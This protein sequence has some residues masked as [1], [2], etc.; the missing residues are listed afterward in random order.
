M[1]QLE[2]IVLDY[3]TGPAK[4]AAAEANSAIASNEKAAER[5]GQ[6]ATRASAAQG[7][8]IVRITDRSRQSTERLV[9]SVERR[10]ITLK[11]PIDRLLAEKQQ[12]LDRVGGDPAAIQRVT[13]AFDKLIANQKKVE[14]GAKALDLSGRIKSGLQ[15]PLGAAGAA[16]SSFV[17]K[18]GLIGAV[19]GGVAVGVG[20]AAKSMFDLV[21]GQG[22]AA[23]ATLNL[24]DRLGIT[25]S[26]ASVLEGQARI[27]GVSVDAFGGLVRKLSTD[28]AD[29]GSEARQTV[30][31]LEN[32]GIVV[33][34]AGG[35]FRDPI[36]ILRD[37][38]KQLN[39]L[40]DH[41]R[42]VDLLSRAFGKGAVELLPLIKNFEATERQSRATGTALDTEIKKKLAEVD[43]RLNQL[44]LSWERIKLKL[45]EKIVTGLEGVVSTFGKIKAGADNVLG[46]TGTKIASIGVEALAAAKAF[47]VLGGP[48]ALGFVAS[49]LRGITANAIEAWVAL[50]G[51]IPGIKTLLVNLADSLSRIPVILKTITTFDYAT[52]ATGIANLANATRG[53]IVAQAGGFIGAIG[54]IA[55]AIRGGG[56]LIGALTLGEKA[57]LGIGQAALIAGAGFAGWKLGEW[58]RDNVPLVREFGDALADLILRIPGVER[59]RDATW[60]AFHGIVSPAKDLA[61]GIKKATDALEAQGAVFDRQG[62]RTLPQYASY[63]ADIQSKLKGISGAADT[64][65]NRLVDAFNKSSGGGL[66]DLQR[67]LQNLVKQRESVGATIVRSNAPESSVETASVRARI[68]NARSLDKQIQA[69]KDAIKIQSG[70]ADATR[71]LEEKRRDEVAKSQDLILE[72]EKKNLEARMKIGGDALDTLAA[73]GL[74]T[75]R[76]VENEKL[77][78]Q[79]QT[80][81]QVAAL[82]KQ[83]IENRSQLEIDKLR[84][85]SKAK[86]IPA[87][88]VERTVTAINTQRDE[89]LL[90]V[91]RETADA[92]ERA[93]ADLNRGR[94]LRDR[95]FADQ[96]L[97]LRQRNDDAVAS[98]DARSAQRSRDE[99]LDSLA[100]INAQ[101]L[102]Q[103]LAVEQARTAIENRFLKISEQAN[104]Q[105]IERRLKRE[106]DLLDIQA[107]RQGISEAERMKRRSLIEQEFQIERR[108]V[109]E[110]TDAAIAANQRKTAIDSARIVNE[111]NLSIFDRFKRESEGIFDAMFA[112]GQNVFQAIGNAFKN[113]MLTAIK[114]VVSSRVAAS[115]TQLVTGQKVTLQPG[116]TGAGPLGRLAGQLGVGA[117][118]VFGK[119]PPIELKTKLDISNHLGDLQLVRGAAPV[120]VVNP[121]QGD[122]KVAAAL[123]GV[124]PAL[125]GIAVALGSLGSKAGLKAP[126][127]IVESTFNGV[128]TGP[129]AVFGV[130]PAAALGPGGTSG[131]AGPLAQSG[132]LGNVGQTTAT[133]PFVPTGGNG[134]ILG[135]LK[136]GLG[137][138]K[139]FLG[140]GG[141]VQYGPGQ[142][143]TFG[144]ASIGQKLSALGRSNAALLGGGL[145][146][147]DGLRRGGLAGLGET[148]A[149]GALIGF[150]F[151]GPI[152]AAIGAGVGA[153]AG[154]I[155]LF[156]KGASEKLRQKIKDTY[157][158]DISD[159]G[160]LTQIAN[161]AKQNYGG[162]L[163]MAI[164]SQPVRELIELYQMA[165]GGDARGIVDRPVAS[166]FSNSG[167]VLSATPSF[168]NGQAVLPGDLRS[169][170]GTP[171]LTSQGYVTDAP[172]RGANTVGVGSAD[173]SRQIGQAVSDAL[174]AAPIIVQSQMPGEAVGSYLEGRMVQTITGNPRTI[175]EAAV[176]GQRESAGRRET[177]TNVLRPN[178]LTA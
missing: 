59:L 161:I 15:D 86:G 37:F 170:V 126:A 45:S 98:I 14:E 81:D 152:G 145:L 132:A 65:A 87:S 108:G 101:T 30:Q 153:I 10:L 47:Q 166:V 113:A 60:T 22:R 167:G 64:T 96:S 127:G 154:T 103:K 76:Q 138:L 9:A 116:T 71:A 112:K 133:P 28:L 95:E 123:G 20:L 72:N 26:E 155:R 137:G 128:S 159:K 89:R 8:A 94:L 149:G 44:G 172:V 69:T 105:S 107:Q 118:P 57:L 79:K 18:F 43:D 25:I 19:A 33:G 173:L 31:A 42:Q 156:F 73:R 115:L 21:E 80:I 78:I 63:L 119:Q 169:S 162:N 67:K 68:E 144:A 40:P 29:G 93:D 48:T 75:L 74:L 53:L 4:Q 135:S 34:A 36:S 66:D 110:D 70:L 82:E 139:E 102:D 83:A 3:D 178:F 104:F 88:T 91:D 35:K 2:R 117:V 38:S 85:D 49:S 124:A 168:F 160:V 177:A 148:T 157:R 56:G 24:S 109:A 151:G 100:L 77:I 51:K 54:N 11:N 16:A 122:G 52:V 97:T 134:G 146:A 111:Y 5:A 55:V 141:G 176:Q 164:R 165:H 61:E 147:A 12:S 114:D 158:V 143:T 50:P 7:D 90:Q 39:Q 140:F 58:L 174:A 6:A 163:D 41:A 13:S 17:E 125:G 150:K 27:A 142:A 171:R 129:G 131:F 62:S 121:Q 32:I 99:Q 136:G 92:R 23:E 46:P 130:N 106:L 120:Y 1:P 175:S 84:S